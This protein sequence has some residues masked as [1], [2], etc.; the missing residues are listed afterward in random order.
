M[1]ESCFLFLLF[2]FLFFLFLLICFSHY[3]CFPV[4]LPSIR[5]TVYPFSPSSSFTFIRLPL[6]HPFF[7]SVFFLF[8][9]FFSLFLCSYS[10]SFLVTFFVSFPSYSCCSLSLSLCFCSSIFSFYSCSLFLFV[11]FPSHL[12]YVLSFFYPILLSF[13]A[14]SLFLFSYSSSFFVL[15][16]I[17]ISLFSC[18]VI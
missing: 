4:P 10:S 8:V 18:S 13:H 15:L 3:H 7:A 9:S 6:I 5:F 17:L 11:P 2:F 16:F 1:E 12:F 14:L